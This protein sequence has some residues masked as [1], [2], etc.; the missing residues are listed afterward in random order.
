MAP[1]GVP[2]SGYTQKSPSWFN[3]ATA[4]GPDAPVL[5]GSYTHSASLDRYL[6]SDRERHRAGQGVT[7]GIAAATARVTSVSV[8]SD[9]F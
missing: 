2:Q 6:P 1:P 8:V 7:P 3:P 4:D 5:P 9:I